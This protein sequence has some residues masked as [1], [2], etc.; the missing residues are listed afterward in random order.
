MTEDSKPEWGTMSAQHMV[1]HLEY[2]LRVASGEIQ[3]FDIQTPEKIL[4]KVHETIYTHQ[5]MPRNYEAPKVL[6][7]KIKD[8]RYES[9]AEAKQKLM[10][11]YDEFLTYF[12]ENPEATTKNAKGRISPYIPGK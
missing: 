7:D 4:E 3:D 10:E 9:L 12:K 2:S 6:Q 5:P 8:L 1:E 11:A